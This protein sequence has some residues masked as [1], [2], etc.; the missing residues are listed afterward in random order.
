VRIFDEIV[1]RDISRRFAMYRMSANPFFMLFYQRIILYGMDVD[2][3]V[4][5]G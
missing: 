4:V 2:N 5:P 3:T 1:G